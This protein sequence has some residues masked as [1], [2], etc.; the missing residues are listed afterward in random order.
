[1]THNS[2]PDRSTMMAMFSVTLYTARGRLKTGGWL[3][4]LVTVCKGKKTCVMMT[5]H[6]HTH[7]CAHTYTHMCTHTYTHKHTHTCEH[8]HT[9][10]HTPHHKPL[11]VM[12]TAALLLEGRLGS[13]S[14]AT[15]ENTYNGV[16]SL[17]R[18][19]EVRMVPPKGSTVKLQRGQERDHVIN[20]STG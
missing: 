3:L 16:V 15:P 19:E 11:M 9:Y 7:T 14:E 20:R 17:F 18:D 6:T 1:M 10:T 12:L 13:M 4:S 2:P 8:T 5:A